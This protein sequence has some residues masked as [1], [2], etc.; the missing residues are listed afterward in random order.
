MANELNTNELRERNAKMGVLERTAL[1]IISDTA[2]RKELTNSINEKK[3]DLIILFD[4]LGITD[5]HFDFEEEGDTKLVELELKSEPRTKLDKAGLAETLEVER[6]E[7]DTMGI[8]EL[9]EAG[10]LTTELYQDHLITETKTK[11]L[12]KKKRKPAA[13]KKAD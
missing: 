8:I 4:E 12:L 5:H 11:I 9:S 7:L 3:E 1:E 13:N 6:G 2:K 10:T